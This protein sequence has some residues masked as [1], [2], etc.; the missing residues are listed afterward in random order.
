MK[1]LLTELKA[2]EEKRAELNKGI[3]AILEQVETS[4]QWH[5]VVQDLKE[6]G[7]DRG[8]IDHYFYTTPLYNN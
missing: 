5:S 8:T 2:V 4:E 3:Y 1:S 6:G 7:C